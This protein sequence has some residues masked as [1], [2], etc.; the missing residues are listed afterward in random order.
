LNKYKFYEKRKKEE[1]IKYH[2]I[3]YVVLTSNV[4]SFSIDMDV[5]TAKGKG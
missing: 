3:I 4:I 1:D 2:M 5:T